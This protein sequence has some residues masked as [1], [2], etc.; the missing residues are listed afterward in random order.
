MDDL[1]T[2]NES[3]KKVTNMCTR[4][5]HHKPCFIILIVWNMFPSRKESKAKSLNAHYHVYL[6]QRDRLQFEIFAWQ[7]DQHKAKSL[8]STYEDA[9]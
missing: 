6:N 5:A 8:I 7:I 4:L 1:L 3:S 2:E 9:T